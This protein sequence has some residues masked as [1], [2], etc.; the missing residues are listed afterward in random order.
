MNILNISIRALKL[1]LHSFG[2]LILVLKNKYMIKEPQEK[3]RIV[4]KK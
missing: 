3:R 2:V 1:L 4:K